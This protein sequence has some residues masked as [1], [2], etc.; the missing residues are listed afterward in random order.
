[1][2][3]RLSGHEAKELLDDYV[4]AWDSTKDRSSSGAPTKSCKDIGI[5]AQLAT[6]RDCPNQDL[7]REMRS[8]AQLRAYV[9]LAG[10][11]FSAVGI[12]CADG[13]FIQPDMQVMKSF[14]RA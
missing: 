2:H 7:Y 1:M 8:Q 10:A 9:D 4:R 5:R 3:C 6:W 11:R 12:R 14:R 13:Y